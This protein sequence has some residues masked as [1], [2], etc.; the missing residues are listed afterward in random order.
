MKV[1]ENDVP[2]CFITSSQ[3][4]EKCSEGSNFNKVCCNV[5]KTTIQKTPN[6]FR[7]VWREFFQHDRL[8]NC[9]KPKNDLIYIFDIFRTVVNF[10]KR[11]AKL[12]CEFAIILNFV[13]FKINFSETRITYFGL[14]LIKRANPLHWVNAYHSL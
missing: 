8:V 5:P 2:L 6:N 3:E 11:I 12:T 7:T 13:I 4:L 9:F 14:N 1:A 10:L